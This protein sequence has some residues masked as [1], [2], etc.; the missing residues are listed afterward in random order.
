MTDFVQRSSQAGPV[1]WGVI[2]FGSKD[3]TLIPLTLNDK[4]NRNQNMAQLEVVNILASL[5]PMSHNN[6]TFAL[7]SATKMYLSSSCYDANVILVTNGGNID[8][9]KVD[10]LDIKIVT[11]NNYECHE[12]N[13]EE[14]W[15]FEHR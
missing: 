8:Y 5:N 7:E 9:K 13:P 14:C 4:V 15:Q 11:I 10:G 1:K 12:N 3:E 2:L 6:G